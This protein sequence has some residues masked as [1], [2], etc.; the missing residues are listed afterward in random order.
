MVLQAVTLAWHTITLRQMV[1]INYVIFW[2]LQCHRLLGC[3]ALFLWLI[4]SV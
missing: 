4:R 2:R 1:A 3:K